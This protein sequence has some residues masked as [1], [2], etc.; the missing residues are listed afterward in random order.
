MSWRPAWST[1]QVQDSQ[2]YT[3]KLCLK[4]PRNKTKNKHQH[5]KL[6][7]EEHFSSFKGTSVH[8]GFKGGN[9]INFMGYNLNIASQ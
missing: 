5:L 9:Y 4:K 2:G 1:N 7:E 6:Q 3:E 8:N